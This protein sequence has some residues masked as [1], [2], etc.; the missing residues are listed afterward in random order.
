V[1]GLSEPVEPLVVIAIGWHDPEADLPEPFASRE[2]APRVRLPLG[3]LLLTPAD[4]AL[5]MSA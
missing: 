1:F 2:R 4:E 3:R 5:P